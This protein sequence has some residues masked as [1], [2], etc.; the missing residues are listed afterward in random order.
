M[1]EY[2]QDNKK[3]SDYEVHAEISNTGYLYL[4]AYN[5]EY[6]NAVELN[7]CPMCGRDLKTKEMLDSIVTGKQIGRAHV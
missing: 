1:C 2:C 6:S 3:L 4:S 5:S 7:F